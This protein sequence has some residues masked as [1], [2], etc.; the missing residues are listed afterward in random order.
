[1][2][3]IGAATTLRQAGAYYGRSL[4][5]RA[6]L[7]VPS[8]D[9]KKLTKLPTFTNTDCVVLDLEDGVA[10][11]AKQTARENIFR[12]LNESASKINREICVRINSMSSNHINDDVKLLKDLSTLIDCLFVPKVDS[13][14]EI[15]WL[16]DRLGSNRQY[17]LVL[18]CESA[19]SL[20]DLRSILTSASNLFPLQGVVFGSDDFSADVGINGR[21]SLDAYELTYARQKLVTICR[22]FENAQPID[23]VYINFKDLDGLKKQSEQ[24]AA[25]GFTGK[26]VI[27]PQQVPVVQTAFSPSESSI[28]WAKELIQAYEK[29]EKE[30][31]KGAFT[32]RGQ[33]M[34]DKPLLRRARYI[35]NMTR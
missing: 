14:D 27:H 15:K 5:R 2:A 1:M 4:P 28:I 29:H 31:G 10:D 22:L 21:Y 34:V 33:T 12:Y 32:F 13:I 7:T 17:N 25:W 3:A 6:V 24:G 23:M 18:Y 30:E 16:A 9:W 19:Q 11:T 20:V 35:L 8:S 26:Q